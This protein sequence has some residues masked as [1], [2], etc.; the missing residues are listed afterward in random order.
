MNEDGELQRIKA[1]LEAPSTSCGGKDPQAVRNIRW[2]IALVESQA[3]EIE[4]LKSSL[5]L[6]VTPLLRR[7]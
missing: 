3:Q 6:D 4:Q 5:S 7:A 1:R 2:L